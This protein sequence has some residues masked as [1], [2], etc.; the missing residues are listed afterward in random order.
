VASSVPAITRGEAIKRGY[1]N[2]VDPTGGGNVDLILD[3]IFA[4]EGPGRALVSVPDLDVEK[5]NKA[6]WQL[7]NDLG[8][9][10][11]PGVVPTA[12]GRWLVAFTRALSHNRTPD[13]A[14]F[15]AWNE[16]AG[17]SRAQ[18]P[19]IFSSPGAFDA[20]RISSVLEQ[21]IDALRHW[22]AGAPFAL[23]SELAQRLELPITAT[24]QAVGRRLRSLWSAGDWRMDFSSEG[25][26]SETAALLRSVLT[27]PTLMAAGAPTPPRDPDDLLRGQSPAGPPPGRSG[28]RPL[29]PHDDDRGHF[30]SIPRLDVPA[31]QGPRVSVRFDVPIRLDET[32]PAPGQGA[33]PAQAGGE[34]PRFT[35]VRVLRD[36]D[37]KEVDQALI[38]E[39][40]YWLQVWIDTKRKG[41]PVEGE[42]RGIR[43]PKAD[44]AVQLFV[45]LAPE[46]ED[47]WEIRTRIDTLG[48]PT[49]GASD[50][51]QF[52]ICPRRLSR[53][54]SQRPL[55][56]RVY[57]RLNLIDSLVLRP[58]VV[59]KSNVAATVPDGTPVRLKFEDTETRGLAINPNL[60]PRAVNI[61][62]SRPAGGGDGT[63]QFTVVLHVAGEELP[64]VAFAKLSKD[65]LDEIIA[66]VRAAWAEVVDKRVYAPG[67]QGLRTLCPGE[68]GGRRPP[69]VDGSLWVGRRLARV[70]EHQGDAQRESSAARGGGAD[71]VRGP[72]S[73]FHLP[74]AVALS[75]RIAGRREPR[76]VLGFPLFR[77]GAQ[78][79]SGDGGSGQPAA[80]YRLCALG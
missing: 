52:S 34:P 63:W 70:K 32:A 50:H 69:S 4:P 66:D 57:Y 44:K 20:A 29:L 18:L 61:T 11:V 53:A 5:L 38:E 28:G 73:R 1:A 35:C 10:V 33:E 30:E 26:A 22:P 37:R 68:A 8:T 80:P 47:A 62:L 14:L 48:L 16:L 51:A 46:D 27:P 9:V 39:Q 54:P 78:H 45:V 13:V 36:S 12:V 74:V 40:K 7:L 25:N 49:A 59:P 79:R 67:D 41:V 31:P 58:F 42:D 2:L 77:R 60:E 17:K 55:R 43:E 19:V 72:G 76:E 71:R 21:A 3:Q 6:A 23:S 65:K 24:A 15:E 64:F 56:I 75:G